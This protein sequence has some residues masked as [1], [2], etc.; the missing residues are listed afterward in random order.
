MIRESYRQKE[1]SE[2]I[3]ASIDGDKSAFDEIVRKYQGM[4]ARTV[5]GMLGDS[6]FTED[7]GQEVFVKLFFS[8]SEFRG[9][10]NYRRT[11]RRLP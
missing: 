1:D 3:R 4:V 6:V 10:Q 9:K 7:I 5:K 2:L 8:L 11:F